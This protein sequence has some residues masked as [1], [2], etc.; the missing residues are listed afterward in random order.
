MRG[1]RG[2]IGAGRGHVGLREAF[3]ADPEIRVAA[4]VAALVDFQKAEVALALPRDADAR[5]VVG[6]AGRK[7]DPN[8]REKVC[9]WCATIFTVASKSSGRLSARMSLRPRRESLDDVEPQVVR[10]PVC[11]CY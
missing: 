9:A 2:Q 7:I 5:D 10:I 1:Q 3:E 4:A 6:P 11:I 8:G